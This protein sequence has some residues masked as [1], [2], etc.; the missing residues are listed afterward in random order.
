MQVEQSREGSFIVNTFEI[1]KHPKVW[2]EIARLIKPKKG[3]NN[4]T[5]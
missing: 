3:L 5:C 4:T 2:Y 1:D